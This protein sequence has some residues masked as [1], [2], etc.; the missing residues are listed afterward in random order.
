MINALIMFYNV[1][2]LQKRLTLTA[3][4]CIGVLNMFGDSS[5]M[6]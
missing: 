4:P 3:S 5:I 2:Y 1:K 6:I